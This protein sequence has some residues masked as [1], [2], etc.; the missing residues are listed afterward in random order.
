M[1]HSRS[2]RVQAWLLLGTALSSGLLLNNNAFAQS[3]APAQQPAQQSTPA[4]QPS[5]AQQQAPVP[6]ATP[7][8]TSTQAP[9]TTTPAN[10][11][12]PVVVQS[13]AQPVV[14]RPAPA[15]AARPAV[16][17][18]AQTART[19][20]PVTQ[21]APA[22][23]GERGIGPVD[24][25]VATQSVTATKMDTPI[26]QTPQS[27]SVVTQDQIQAQAAQSVS[28]ALWYTPGITPLAFG[29]NA[30][31]D[32]FKLRG[33]D[34][35]RYLDGLR[36]PNDSTTFAIPKI[37]VY[38]LERLEVLKGPSSALYGQTEPGGL[39]NMVSKRPMDRAHFEVLGTF[40]SYG[41]Y[42]SAFDFGGP[43]DKKG[44]FLYR[45]V[46]LGRLSDTQTDFV[47]D[48]EI[49]IA[50]SFTWRPTANTTFT[51]LSQYQKLNNKG[52]Q[53]Y[54]P[55]QVSFMANPNGFVP[56][57]RYLG[58]PA[59]DGYKLEQA[60]I[61]YAF[62][63]RFNNNLQFRQNIR[64]LEVTN[65]LASARTEGMLSSTLVARTYNYVKANASNLAV[66]NQ[67]QADFATGIL[68]HKVLAGLDHFN[69][70]AGTDYRSG[71]IAP[72]DAYNP[73]Y[74]APVPSFDSLA[75]FI[76]RNDRQAQT[77]LYLQD[78]VQV[79]RW[80]FLFTGR[81][82]WV[83]SDFDSWAFYPPAGHYN[84]TDTAPTWRVG[85]SYLFDNGVAPYAT[86]AT[87]FTPNLGADLAG[88]PFKPTTGEGGEFGIKYKP[89]GI[90][91]MVTA[92][93]FD[94]IRKDILTTSPINPLFSVQTDAVRVRGFEFEA[95]GNLSRELEFVLGY[96]HIDPKVT[97]SIAGYAG[98]YMTNTA[99]DQ[100]SAWAKYTWR[101]G[102]LAGFGIGGGVRYVGKTYGNAT[103]TLVVP[104]YTVLDATVSYDLGYA[105]PYLKGWSTQLNV[106]NLA[107]RYYVASCLTGTPYCSFGTGRT[108]LGTIKYSTN[109]T[110]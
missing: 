92:S 48:N 50:P 70:R 46:G 32:S 107:D 62:E 80:T 39:I 47:Q 95:K 98:T 93:V 6:P 73:I 84:T 74:G 68:T 28:E 71:G 106:T 4:Q 17:P 82:D 104:S 100:A 27:I 16:R 11:L 89:N 65:D 91:M 55:A 76:L 34:A 79:D 29:A 37:E 78:Q 67:L 52:Y 30:F 14:R 69:L 51:I 33:F 87:S 101:T 75:P 22:Q 36:L 49:F 42:Q 2:I 23:A 57:S 20:A 77:G 25:F 66:D 72:I 109:S 108:V 21:A 61:G 43:L 56:Y 96:S 1:E 10:Q 41:R 12:P 59:S 86:Y 19:T 88:K 105:R 5:P 90:D 45:V 53:Q 38:G 64:Y 94:I 9:P 7:P 24:G 110:N 54:I 13:P 8:A 26:L 3:D 102:V 18:R 40:G 15:R 31:F 103:N 60:S 81:R 97:E 83:T 85:V 63:H 99:L 58:E 44:E 35:P